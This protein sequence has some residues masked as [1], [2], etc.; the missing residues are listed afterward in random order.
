MTLTPQLI[1]RFR[2]K[3]IAVVGDIIADV[4]VYGMPYKLSRKHPWW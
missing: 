3:K 2:G 4:Y 1:E